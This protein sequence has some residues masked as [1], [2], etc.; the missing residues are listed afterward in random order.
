MFLHLLC[1]TY[2]DQGDNMQDSGTSPPSALLVHLASTSRT[3]RP[4]LTSASFPACPPGIYIKDCKT[5]A[6]ISKFLRPVHFL[7]LFYPLPD[8]HVVYLHKWL[9]KYCSAPEEFYC[10]IGLLMYMSSG[11]LSFTTF[12]ILHMWMYLSCLKISERSMQIYQDYKDL[13]DMDS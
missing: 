12:L 13:T 7:K 1:Y 4:A 10:F 8:R 11:K 9:W 3:A 5:C 2:R 6:D